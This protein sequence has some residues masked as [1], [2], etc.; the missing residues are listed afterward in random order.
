MTIPPDTAR[1]LCEEMAEIIGDVV[2]GMRDD[3]EGWC[4]ICG[5]SKGY[6]HGVDCEG[7]KLLHWRRRWLD[8]GGREK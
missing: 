8:A 3:H 7:T 2:E 6:P 4:R 5:A 1:A